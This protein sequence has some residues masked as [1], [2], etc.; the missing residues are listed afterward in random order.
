MAR[1]SLRS[2]GPLL[3]VC[4]LAAVALIGHVTAGRGAPEGSP[5]MVVV[6]AKSRA[7]HCAQY[8]PTTLRAL[9]QGAQRLVLVVHAFTPPEPPDGT[10]VVWLASDGKATP[11]EVAR[12]AIHPLRAFARADG[13]DQ[14]FAVSLA[15]QPS[16]PAPG[17]PLCLEVGFDT[18]AHNLAG[19]RAETEIVLEGP[20]PG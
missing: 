5:T 10:L 15:G 14:R 2:R 20:D 3:L 18:A 1:H 7:R 13:K 16:L 8:K 9:E 17:T 12:V 6:T 19:G 4:G 11:R